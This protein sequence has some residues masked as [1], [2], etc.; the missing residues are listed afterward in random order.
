LSAGPTDNRGRLTR[1][2]V[3]VAAPSIALSACGGGDKGPPTTTL[4]FI[5]DGDEFINPNSE[6]EPSPV[7]VRVYELKVLTAFEQ[8]D[9]Y[10]LLDNDTAA[11]GADLVAKREFEIK[12]GERQGFDR[13]SPDDTRYIGVIAGY[14]D[15]QNAT[16]RASLESKP[17]QSGLFVI[18]L[19]ALSVSISFVRDKTLGLF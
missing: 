6:S 4:R 7:V 2:A 19:T 16:W 18:K 1:R 9:F 10:Q 8:A 13:N 5:I 15:I 17:G 11:L 14:R 12:P 3:I